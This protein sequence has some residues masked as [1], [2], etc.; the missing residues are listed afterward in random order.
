ME[1]WKPWRKAI[2]HVS[3]DV[4]RVFIGGY[5]WMTAVAAYIG[6]GVGALVGGTLGHGRHVSHS[7]QSVTIY[8]STRGPWLVGAIAVALVLV[9]FAIAVRHQRELHGH[10]ESV[11][12]SEFVAS[13][14]TVVRTPGP[15]RVVQPAG[16]G[17]ASEG[18][19]GP[20]GAGTP[21]LPGPSGVEVAFPMQPD[22]DD[23][24]ADS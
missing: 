12:E 4:V 21:T 1:K 20:A 14:G 18:P 24:N 11:E 10:A 16:G 3:R 5:G 19:Q 6:V 8:A 13:D 23:G 7:G 17:G 2:W 15:M 9:V 22:Q